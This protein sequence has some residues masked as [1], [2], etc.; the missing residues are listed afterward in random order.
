MIRAVIFDLDDT[1]YDEMQFVQGGFK[2]VSQYVS[3]YYKVDKDEVY[4]LLMNVLVDRGRGQT[5]DVA[6]KRLGLCNEAS[7]PKLVTIYRNH[8]PHLY[9]HPEVR[10]VL[11]EL[12]DKGYRLG[13]ITD[14]DVQVQKSKVRALKIKD[15]FDYTLFSYEHGEDRCKPS[16]FPFQEAVEKLGVDPAES[17]YV[18]DNPLKDFAGANRLGMYTVRVLR[19]QNRTIEVESQYKA[20]VRIN[21]LCEIFDVLNGICESTPQ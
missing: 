12:K 7:I 17:V 14:G 9:L 6:L 11:C 10:S 4:D 20:R 19:G 18:G 5:F 21:T 1:L 16:P 13:L 15:F 3:D 8:E 2:A